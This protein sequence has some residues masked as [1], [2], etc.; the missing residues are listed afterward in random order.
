MPPLQQ[1][2]PSTHTTPVVPEQVQQLF[3]S[4]SASITR[5]MVIELF[6]LAIVLFGIWRVITRAG[7]SPAWFL[8]PLSVPV[9]TFVALAQA[10]DGHLSPFKDFVALWMDSVFSL[11]AYTPQ[12]ANLAGGAWYKIVGWDV[13]ANFVL[14][15]AFALVRWPVAESGGG[16]A[17][18]PFALGRKPTPEP[19]GGVGSVPGAHGGDGL[20]SPSPDGTVS[21]TG[22]GRTTATLPPRA[23]GRPIAWYPAEDGSGDECYWDGRSWT[24]RR[25]PNGAGRWSIVSG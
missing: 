8:A 7:F 19:A 12:M 9:L 22:A 14:F 11:P 23:I 3:Q 5:D 6:V 2:I 15:V 1:P 25:R 24:G 10:A 16:G 20:H 13:I 4:V 21:T 17:S 18:R